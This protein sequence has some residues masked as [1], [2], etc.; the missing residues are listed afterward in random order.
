[1]V[2]E[3]PDAI[4]KNISL[5]DELIEFVAYNKTE[6]IKNI[7]ANGLTSFYVIFLLIL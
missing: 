3:E 6:L 4:A 7:L 2:L 1:M 5:S